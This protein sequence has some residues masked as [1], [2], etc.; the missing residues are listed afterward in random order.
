MKDRFIRSWIFNQVEYSSLHEIE[1]VRA[2]TKVHLIL[3]LLLL[4]LRI[5]E[6]RWIEAWHI[7]HRICLTAHHSHLRAL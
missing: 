7:S 3:L 1:G 2:C 4:L 6:L 5:I